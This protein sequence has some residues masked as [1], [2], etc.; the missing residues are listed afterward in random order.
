[1]LAIHHRFIGCEFI[2]YALGQLQ[3]VSTVAGETAKN[4]TFIGNTFADIT[5]PVALLA[6]GSGTWGTVACEWAS[7]R[8]LDGQPVT[9]QGKSLITAGMTIENGNANLSGELQIDGVKAL[10]PKDTGWE[11]ATGT[12]SKASFNTATVTTE[13]LAQQVKALK[14]LVITHHGLAGT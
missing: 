10:G 1:V 13:E 5:T 2:Q 3:L 4:L 12:A 6:E 8:D 7:N 9:I 11:A 14:D